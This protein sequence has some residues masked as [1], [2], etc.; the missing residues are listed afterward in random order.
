MAIKVNKT[1]MIRIIKEFWP[2]YRDRKFSDFHDF[3]KISREST[4]TILID[5][6]QFRFY[7]S[8]NGYVLAIYTY[9]KRKRCWTW[10]NGMRLSNFFMLCAFPELDFTE[11]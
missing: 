9:S 5:D 8:S 6:D 2:D 4:W 7:K 10:V 1:K 3:H 11:V